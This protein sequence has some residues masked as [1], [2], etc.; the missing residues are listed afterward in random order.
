M[1]FVSGEAALKLRNHVIISD[2][3]V[4]F[5]EYLEEKGYT[6]PDQTGN[7]LERLEKLS[8]LAT[9]LVILGDVKHTII[10]KNKT[11]LLLFLSKI[12]ELFKKIVI[13]KG[14]HDGGIEKYTE[15]FSNI[16]VV[17]EYLIG[18][19]LLI[20]GHKY[21]TP[22]AM[23]KA[24]NVLIGHFHSAHQLKDHLGLVKF[25]K[26]WVVHDF[27]NQLF[28]K[29]RR[30]KTSIVEVI[31]FPCFNAFFDG[32]GEKNG[33]YAQFLNKKEVFTLDLVKLL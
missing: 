28:L 4:G 5:E 19:T 20:H 3:H 9:N 12:S 13:I 6:I 10:L 15:D 27:N 24:R 23:R 14:N 17:S 22:E 30:V 7:A 26:T 29:K 8:K 33:P 32:G 1:E 11:R 16:R 31:G 18:K 25:R 2:V 21:A